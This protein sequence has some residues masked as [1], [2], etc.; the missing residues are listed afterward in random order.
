MSIGLFTDKDH[1][2]TD[3]E[4]LAAVGP[5]LDLWQRLLQFIRTSYRAQEDLKFMYGHP[6]GWALRFRVRGKLLTALYPTAGG[7][8][9]QIILSTAAVEQAQR[10]PLGPHVQQVIAQAHPYPEGRWLF[11]P[12]RE[13]SDASDVEQL[14]P[15]RAAVKPPPGSA[16]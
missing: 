1:P 7:F 12:V 6:Y 10:V 9:V 13:E 8:T 4:I 14:L 2:P 11:I 15:L 3:A 16:R 5:R